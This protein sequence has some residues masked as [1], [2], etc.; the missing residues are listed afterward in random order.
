MLA[1]F[2]AA[3]KELRVC[4]CGPKAS[5]WGGGEPLNNEM[6]PASDPKQKHIVIINIDMTYIYI[7]IIYKIPFRFHVDLIHTYEYTVGFV[8]RPILTNS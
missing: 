3:N 1:S 8:K 4:E 6:M 2:A 7:Q 5:F